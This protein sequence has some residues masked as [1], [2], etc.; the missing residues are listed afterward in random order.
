MPTYLVRNGVHI[1][2][3][4][5]RD[6][7]FL[8]PAAPTIVQETLVKPDPINWKDA[9]GTPHR[10]ISQPPA[11]AGWFE[12]EKL[13]DWLGIDEKRLGQL[14]R[15]SQVDAVYVRPL[16][17]PLYRIRDAVKLAMTLA[18]PTTKKKREKKK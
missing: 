16:G 11:D 8:A 12:R 13:L 17:L 3:G 10:F 9:E 1:P 7:R 18:E 4:F 14:V 2:V 6:R 15:D 5:N